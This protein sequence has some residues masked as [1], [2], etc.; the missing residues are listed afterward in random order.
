MSTTNKKLLWKLLR[1]H[2]SRSQ[3]LGFALAN[4]VGLAIVVLAVQFYRDVIPVFN[5]EESFIRKDYLIITRSVTAS[6]A[7]MGGASEFSDADIADIEAQEWCRKVGRFTNS[8]FSIWATIGTGQGNRA[9]RSQFF[10]ESIPN[11]FIDIDPDEWGFNPEKPEVPVIVSRDYLSL[12]N[13]GFAAAQG[14][15]KISEGQAGMIPVSFTFSGAG[16][17]EVIPG[18]IVGFSNRLNTI[19]VPDQFMKWGNERY[20]NSAQAQRPVRLILEVNRPGDVV[21]QDYMK[22]HHY[23]V[24][25]DK[26]TSS[27]AYYFLTLIIGIV[28]VVGIVISALSF[29][30][31]ML[32]IYLLL[33]KNTQK[34]RNLLQLGYSP[35][36][37][38]QTYIRMVVIINAVVLVLALLLMF[39]ARAYYMPSMRALGTNG[40][41]LWVSIVVGIVIMAAITTGNVVAI[42][43]KINSLWVQK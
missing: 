33:Q 3:L 24:A 41:S 15:P 19:I 11:D 21:I 27:K 17:N 4:L 14:M 31:L 9:M 38:A 25:G 2:V 23:D 34:L 35:A 18:K 39:A 26:M 6:G 5:D 22:D 29:F 40:S 8:E 7:M 32:S 28:V 37:T 10:F 36:Q 43:R 1:K 13:F 12:Y 30:V 16:R 42:K 20:G